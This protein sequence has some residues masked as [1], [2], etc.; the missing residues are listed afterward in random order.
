M[1]YLKK[2]AIM[3]A[4]L[5]L[6]LSIAALIILFARGY[7]YNPKSKSLGSQGILVANSAPNSA[8]IYVNNK[9]VSLT[10]N[11]VYLNPGVYQITIRKEG[12]SD[13]T[14]RFNIKGEVVSRV[15]AQLFSSNPSL[16]PLTN[17]GIINPTLSPLKDKISYIMLPDENQP[18]LEEN[19]G[20]VIASLKSNTLSFFR[21]HSLI[22]PFSAFPTQTDP[23]QVKV[24]F[25]PNQ[26]N[27]LVFFFDQYQNPLAVYLVSPDNSNGNY[28]DVSL[29]YSQLLNKWWQEKL[30]WQEK[31]YDTAKPKLR[32]VLNNNTYL[33]EISPDKSKFLYLAL[34]N[35]KLPRVITPPLI[36]SV[37]TQET[38][39]I[40]QAN[41]YLYDQK[42]DKNFII[43]AFGAT[44]RQ[45]ITD[46]L[47]Q[48]LHPEYELSLEDWLKT[49]NLFNR[50]IWYSDSRHLVYSHNA[51]I[52]ILEYDGTNQT[53]VY[54]GPFNESFLSN[55]S[56]GRLVILTNINPKKNALED[57]Y[58][59]SVK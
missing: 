39:A 4:I 47:R 17:S 55:S 38:R 53:L 31:I 36:G 18:T 8:Q 11:N 26:K 58:S 22:L 41:V 34:N 45:E 27:L 13:W 20:L 14:K 25:S 54:S 40:T 1:I 49:T 48:I 6:I 23:H 16:S 42:E 19:G 43:K 50:L 57:L 51:T 32:R 56:D 12:Y 9:F 37:P 2:T 35:A 52:S 44:K 29:S 10:S 30:A 7:R 15:D 3:L 21:Q 28:L 5:S 24:V 59:V 33:I 46:Y